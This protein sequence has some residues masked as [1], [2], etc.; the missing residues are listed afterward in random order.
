[1]SEED[2]AERALAAGK[3]ARA[4]GE[5]KLANLDAAIQGMKRR[6]R[7]ARTETSSWPRSEPGA[8]TGKQRRKPD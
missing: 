6:V 8:E 3:K 7:E 1:M 4:K 5:E 2:K